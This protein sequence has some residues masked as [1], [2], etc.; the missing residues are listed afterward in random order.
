MFSFHPVKLLAM[1][2]GG[3][4]STNSRIIVEKLKLL[5]NH[6]IERDPKNL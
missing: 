2:E 4:I 5:R 6:G 1:G 3:V